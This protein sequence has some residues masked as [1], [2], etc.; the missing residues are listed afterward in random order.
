MKNYRLFAGILLAA[1]MLG[2]VFS[3][4]GVSVY[5]QEILTET[6]TPEIPTD[7]PTP[8]PTATETPPA[9]DPPTA[10]PT[11]EVV[12]TETAS[13][14]PTYEYTLTETPTE[15]PTLTPTETPE[16]AVWRLEYDLFY[17]YGF[18][19][20]MGGAS[21]MSADL[22]SF[23]DQAIAGE[24]ASYEL[25][26][27]EDGEGVTFLLVI[28][29]NGGAEQFHR[30]YMGQ[31]KNRFG[32]T[33]AV[34]QIWLKDTGKGGKDWKLS[35]DAQFSNGYAW[36]VVSNKGINESQGHSREERGGPLG[37]RG[38]QIF[39]FNNGKKGDRSVS[40]KYSAP[41]EP[42]QSPTRRIY[43]D[44]PLEQDLLLS[45]EGGE[46]E[47][48]Y[49]EPPPL[50]STGE[51]EL[52]LGA[53]PN[54]YD[55][56]TLGAVPA[57][58]HQGVCGSCYAFATVGVM[59]SAMLIN[60]IPADLSEQFLVSCTRDY[61]MGCNGGYP[62][63]H[64]YHVSTVAKDQLSAGA[65]LES[66]M[67][68]AQR[69][70]SE[71]QACKPVSHPYTLMSWHRISTTW[72]VTATVD[73]LKNAIYT[74]GPVATSICSQSAFANYSGGIFTTNESCGTSKT[75]HAVIL[76]GW[77]TDP[78]H[79]TVWILRN[80]WGSGWGD[81]GYMYVKAGTSNVGNSATYVVY[82]PLPD[83][84]PPTVSKVD[85]YN[86][87]SDNLISMNED[88]TVDVNRLIVIYDEPMYFNNGV[89]DVAKLSNYTLTNL[90]ADRLPGGGDDSNVPL[91]SA[92]YNADAR[93][94]ILMI[95]NN[96][97]LPNSAYRFTISGSG[98]VKDLAGLRL[99]GDA[100][101]TAGGDHV[102]TFSISKKPGTPLLSL[103]ASGSSINTNP[104]QLSWQP[105]ALAASYELSLA[106]DS[107]FTQVIYTKTGISATA[108][109]PPA[110]A[111]GKFYW[112]VRTR[113]SFG[114]PGSWS[115]VW[116]FTM[117]TQPPAVPKLDK[118]A[119]L[120]SSRGMPLFYWLAS[121]GAKVYRLRL[122]DT[123]GGVLYTSA[124]L[125]VLNHRPTEQPP[126]VLLWQVQARDA[127]GNWS[128]WS[129]PRSL[130]I[131]PAIPAAPVL[132]TPK[133]GLALMGSAPTLDWKDVPWAVNYEFQVSKTSDFKAVIQGGTTPSSQFTLI[134]LEDGKYFWRVRG[135]NMDAENGKWSAYSSFTLDNN[136]PKVPAL[137][138][139]GD[140]KVVR[141]TPAYK[142]LKAAGAYR[143]EFRYTTPQGAVLYTSPEL[144]VLNH[145]PPLQDLGNYLWQVRAR[146]AAG[147][148]SEWSSPRAIEIMA[149][150]PAPPK[151]ALPAHKSSGSDSTPALSWNAAPYATGYE[152]QVAK[153]YTFKTAS[154]VAQPTV[155]GALQY[156][157]APLPLS[158]SSTTF[159][160]RV[161]SINIYGEKG[162]W[163][164]YR[165]FK[166][167]Q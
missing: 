35:L 15:T 2:L 45:S 24:D 158:G 13:E 120:S 36:Q 74:K 128:E 52:N 129:A 166:I 125:S 150:I 140:N 21:V 146:D 44:F 57:I 62:D 9:S 25:N 102:L 84:S 126:G 51:M 119:D 30:I 147:N 89:D 112:R 55:W 131:Q 142:W 95:N 26:Q 90:G 149:P 93:K 61:N 103:P 130:L 141:G 5:A 155:N 1:L 143:Y 53:P 121:T 79:G 110:M 23:F 86:T 123:L 43:L 137:Y 59:E 83:N 42:G 38:R 152:V 39:S 114:T 32:T 108:Y 14:T 71:V 58:R 87:T 81:N 144:S 132:L 70:T 124:N 165:I 85:S 113:N 18:L 16:S 106:V 154:I 75:N 139:P 11:P 60:G 101:G 104:A 20:A 159:Y 116:L 22:R 97:N 162:K 41:W 34:T 151:L 160:W 92:S 109:T 118:P 163:S 135:I 77:I 10:T 6:P 100:N 73:E 88:I 37:S 50:E 63:S 99:D 145:K 29:G 64:K 136:P 133:K 48:A 17:P 68:Y 134:A 66:D 8:E 115:V 27:R 72:N 4:P 148:W 82:Q 49:S 65:V 40:L 164:A 12:P 46:P 122:T 19:D 78:T 167:T 47:L 156:T 127:A 3:A 153:T 94:L 56:R 117:D 7:S 138:T 54:S 31:L 157:T 98:T 161:R 28:Q 69:N 80:S 67:P 96:S 111:D 91:T 76:V 107:A 105:A 33:G